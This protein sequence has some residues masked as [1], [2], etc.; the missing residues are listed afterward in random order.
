MLGRM[1]F[2]AKLDAPI[3]KNGHSLAAMGKNDRCPSLAGP[4]YRGN[5]LVL[6][7]AQ[8]EDWTPVSRRGMAAEVG[9]SVH[10][11]QHWRG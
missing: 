7:A 10:A 1:R 6:L 2:T 9:G 4:V 11:L 8:V 5:A 3:R